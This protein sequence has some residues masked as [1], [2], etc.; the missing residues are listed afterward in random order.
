MMLDVG[1]ERRRQKKIRWLD[2][3]I[4][5]E[6]MSMNRLGEWVIKKPEDRSPRNYKITLKESTEQPQ[7]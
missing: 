2:R 7:S 4:D 5:S 6:G 1:G 3:T